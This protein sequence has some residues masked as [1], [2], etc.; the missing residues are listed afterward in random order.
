MTTTHSTARDAVRVGAMTLKIT[1]EQKEA[2]RFYELLFALCERVLPNCGCELVLLPERS[3]L[4]AED[5]QPLDGPHF[6]RF[7]DLARRCGLF[8]LAPLAETAGDGRCYN[9]HAVISPAGALVHAFRKVHLAPGEEK[10]GVPGDEFKAFDL[11][12]FRAGLLICFDNHFP[13]SSRCLALDGAQVLFWPSFGNVARP[14]VDGARAVDNGV[15]VVSAGIV[16]LACDLP[17]E[18]FNR[19]AVTAPNGEVLA[20]SAPEDG[21]AVADL[22]LDPATGRLRPPPSEFQYLARRIPAAY[23]RMVSPAPERP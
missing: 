10:Q 4:R 19:G 22:P 1:R 2:R 21:L 5:I 3:A 23:G 15:Y 20:L 11:P 7:A 8:L 17:G 16:D 9:T 6:R 12:W 14:R 18:V 13:E